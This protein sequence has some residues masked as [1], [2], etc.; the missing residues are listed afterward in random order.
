MYLQ[1]SVLPYEALA[2]CFRSVAL[3][4]L[5]KIIY[6]QCYF[7]TLCDLMYFLLR[8]HFLEPPG[9]DVVVSKCG[10]SETRTTPALP[11]LPSPMILC[12]SVV[13]PLF[14]AELNASTTVIGLLK[15]RYMMCPISLHS[16]GAATV[17]YARTRPALGLQRTTSLKHFWNFY[18]SYKPWCCQLRMSRPGRVAVS[19]NTRNRVFHDTHDACVPPPKPEKKVQQ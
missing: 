12:L 9:H 16:F 19:R 5:V 11:S 2:A 18:S 7:V 3:L 17:A 15:P 14:R 10:G 6:Q 8:L 1:A 13:C 4:G